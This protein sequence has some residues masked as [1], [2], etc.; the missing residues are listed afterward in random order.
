MPKM[1]IFSINPIYHPLG[2]MI[3]LNEFEDV[4][5][6]NTTKIPKYTEWKAILYACPVSGD[7]SDFWVQ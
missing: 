4:L 2:W 3:L 5:V 1:D 7:V 6:R